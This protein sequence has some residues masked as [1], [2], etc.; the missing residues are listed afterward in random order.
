MHHEL[1]RYP[2]P[3]STAAAAAAF[4]LERAREAVEQRGHFHFAVSGGSTPWA[5][6]AAL[7]QL[8]VPWSATTIYQVDDRAAPLDSDD[9]NLMH[10]RESLRNVEV[11]VVPMPVE[12]DLDEGARAYEVLLPDAFD[13]AHLGLGADGHTASLLPG[14]PVLEVE[15]RLVSSTGVYQGWR[16]MTLTY[17]GLARARWLLWLIVGANQYGPLRQLL[18]AD[19]SIPASHVVAPR[20]TIFADEAA[21]P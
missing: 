18:D 11:T 14:D 19:P 6:F 9:R 17:P 8:D 15:D 21:A 3:T 13:V 7:S 2:D 20:S 16:R 4:I 12:G 5:M 1:R 10:L